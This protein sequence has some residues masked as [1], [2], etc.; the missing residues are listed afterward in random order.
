V[1]EVGF[2]VFSCSLSQQLRGA[3][4]NRRES[5][6]ERQVREVI[7]DLKRSF[8]GVHGKLFDL[9]DPTERRWYVPVASA[10][11]RHM[12]S[13]VADTAETCKACIQVRVLA[14]L[15]VHSDFTV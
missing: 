8:P 10:L 1:T 4:D 3:D 7:A 15:F 6:K 9:I 2:C 11:G 14:P 13:I 5:D 12:D